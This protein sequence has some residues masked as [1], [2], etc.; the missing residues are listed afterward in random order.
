M[1]LLSVYLLI[2]TLVTA[3][4]T[5]NKTIDSQKEYRPRGPLIKC[6]FLP[7]EFIECDE[8]IDHKGN[9]TAKEVNQ[10]LGCVK[11]GGARYEDV[12]KAKATCR[13]LPDIECHGEREFNRSGFPCVKYSGHYFTLTLLYSI[14]L[15]FLGMDRFCL[16]QTGTAVGKLLTLGG[17]GV[18]WIVDVFLLVT[19]SLLPED[20][21]N[22][23]PYV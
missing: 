1:I 23:N 19:N 13:V 8:L 5:A 6:T 11:F 21:S 2:A 3:S 9:K 7:M 17:L 4:T 20:G 12:E 15:G 14:L 22:W 18:W 16:G 10:G